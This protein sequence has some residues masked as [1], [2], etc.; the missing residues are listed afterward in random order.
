MVSRCVGTRRR[1][2]AAQA[3]EGLGKTVQPRAHG[4]FP[5]T[6]LFRLL[7]RSRRTP[8]LWIAAPPGAGKTTLVSSYL[9]A[10]RLR[11]AWYQIDEGDADIAAFFFHVGHLTARGR[12]LPVLRPEHWLALSTFARRYFVEL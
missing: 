1:S 4:A 8:I 6:R 5:R 10:R 9:D 7:D 2:R 12:P 3:P 11:A